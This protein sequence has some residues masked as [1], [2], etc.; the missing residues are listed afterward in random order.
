MPFVLI[1]EDERLR[2]THPGTDSGFIYRRPPIHIQREIQAKHTVNGVPDNN[3]VVD[4]LLEWAVIDWFG[5]VD[6]NRAPVQFEKRYLVNGA[7]SE[8][9]K[10]QFIPELYA[11][12][13]QADEL[14]N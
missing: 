5:F 6:K 4:E 3:K 1:S 8:L 12:D 11:F 14:K 2:W 9:Y 10:A 7:I 13:P